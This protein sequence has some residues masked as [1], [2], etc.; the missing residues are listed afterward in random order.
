MK[1]VIR[2]QGLK[3]KKR[4]EITQPLLN[5]KVALC[6]LHGL[7]GI[8]YLCLHFVGNHKIFTQILHKCATQK[9]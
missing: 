8:L 9:S 5:I 1:V 6:D 3:I 4:G 2:L 7:F